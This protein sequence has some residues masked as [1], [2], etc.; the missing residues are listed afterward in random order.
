MWLTGTQRRPSLGASPPESGSA[1]RRPPRTSGFR[2]IK[3]GLAYESG[4]YSEALSGEV[5]YDGQ[6][7]GANWFHAEL[8][9]KIPLLYA[10]ITGSGAFREAHAYQGPTTPRG[11]AVTIWANEFIHTPGALETAFKPA[12]EEWRYPRVTVNARGGV[13]ECT[14]VTRRFNADVHGY[15]ITQSFTQNCR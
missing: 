5:C 7:A 2:C 3:P 1:R 4:A 12:L 8:T 11:R 15:P 6:Q 9:K 14:W 13:H 10:T